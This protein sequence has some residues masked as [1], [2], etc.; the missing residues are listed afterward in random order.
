M[1]RSCAWTC[2]SFSSDCGDRFSE[3][4]LVAPHP[5]GSLS[6]SWSCSAGEVL[7][8]AST[9]HD[10]GNSR[11]K[12]GGKRCCGR[13]PRLDTIVRA[14]K[15]TILWP[16]GPEVCLGPAILPYIVRRADGTIL[17]CRRASKPAV[18][19]TMA[20]PNTPTASTLAGL[21]PQASIGRVLR[22]RRQEHELLGRAC[23]CQ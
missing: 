20:P 23:Q 19:V 16:R 22:A 9:N 12:N 2:S 1:P 15:L 4:A 14:P 3:V 21:I 8:S 6:I 5:L 17:Y 10:V 18:P 11:A 13:S 7:N